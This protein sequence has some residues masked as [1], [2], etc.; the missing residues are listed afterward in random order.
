LI[1]LTDEGRT[2]MAKEREVLCGDTLER[3]FATLGE[4]A[5][6][7][8]LQTMEALITVS[9]NPPRQTRRNP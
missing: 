7:N 2:A 1:W 9:A 6:A 5:R 3:A 8:L 4:S